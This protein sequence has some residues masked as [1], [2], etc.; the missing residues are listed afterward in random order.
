MRDPGARKKR[1]RF[2]FWC[3][4][5]LILLAPGCGGCRGVLTG[6]VTF[7]GEKMTSGS[8]L[9]V[10]PDSRPRTTYILK[11][12]TY[13]FTDLP[14][15]E[16]KL[17]VFT[18]RRN[19][20]LAAALEQ[21]FGQGIKVDGGNGNQGMRIVISGADF[22]RPPAIPSSYNDQEQSGLRTVIRTGANSY[23]IKLEEPGETP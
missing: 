22:K 17:A 4:G 2:A 20:R 5:L 21:M 19:F 14:P 9:L 10:G 12:G 18:S 6:T 7:Q 3:L 23:E 1:G 16:A 13:K 8:V 11:D 15:G